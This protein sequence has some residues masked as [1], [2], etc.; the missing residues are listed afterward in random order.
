[1]WVI[2]A[3]CHIIEPYPNTGKDDSLNS[4]Y[5]HKTNQATLPMI[6][7]KADM[8]KRHFNF[9]FFKCIK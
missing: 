1:K 2:Q 8:L 7:A 9:T 4:K 3:F 6:T 5:H